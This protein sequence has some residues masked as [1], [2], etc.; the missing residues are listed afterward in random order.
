MIVADLATDTLIQRTEVIY[1]VSGARIEPTCVIGHAAGR[2]VN[3][4]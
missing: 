1:P 4:A 2:Y 3:A